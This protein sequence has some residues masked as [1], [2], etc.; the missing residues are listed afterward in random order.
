MPA[1]RN[2]DAGPGLV[3]PRPPNAA[4]GGSLSMPVSGREIEHGLSIALLGRTAGRAARAMQ[5]ACDGGQLSDQQ[6]SALQQAQKQFEEL[7]RAAEAIAGRQFSPDA[8]SHLTS[9]EAIQEAL[10]QGEI[11]NV[12]EVLAAVAEACRKAG[13]S[14]GQ[15][16]PSPGDLE[17]PLQHLGN[18]RAACLAYCFAPR[19][20]RDLTPGAETAQWYG[21]ASGSG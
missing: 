10:D 12:A 21:H 2:G 7:A 11:R 16:P 9:I 18:L 5:V 19:P 17:G 6:L 14:N 8:V 20:P 3:G 13:E 1:G 15:S 4:Q